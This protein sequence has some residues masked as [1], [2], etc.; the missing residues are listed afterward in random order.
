MCNHAVME[1]SC[2][3]ESHSM[4]ES[5]LAAFLAISLEIGYI[6]IFPYYTLVNLVFYLGQATTGLP[7]YFKCLCAGELATSPL[8]LGDF[9]IFISTSDCMIS[10]NPT[11]PASR[12]L[13]GTSLGG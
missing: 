2:T 9:G 6:L 3:A 7:E 4:L 8:M 5:I 12:A 13:I 11:L 10:P 1:N